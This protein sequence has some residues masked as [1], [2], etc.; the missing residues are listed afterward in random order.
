MYIT[1]AIYISFKELKA[2]KKEIFKAKSYFLVKEQGYRCPINNLE[3]PKGLISDLEYKDNLVNRTFSTPLLT[4]YS[5]TGCFKNGN[6]ATM[7]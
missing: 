7:L 5:S 4:N 1:N 6:G 2:F 3:Y